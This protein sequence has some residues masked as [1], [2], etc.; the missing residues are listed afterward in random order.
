MLYF[1]AVHHVHVRIEPYHISN[2][3]SGCSFKTVTVQCF[4]HSY[5]KMHI[6]TFFK[7]TDAKYVMEHL[8]AT[9]ATHAWF[10]RATLPST[11]SSLSSS[12]EQASLAACLECQEIW[13][14]A[15]AKELETFKSWTLQQRQFITRIGHSMYLFCMYISVRKNRFVIISSCDIKVSIKQSISQN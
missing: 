4:W 11:Y 15:E 1:S 10:L 8:S 2:T 12:D 13:S 9:T 6:N 3:R 7:T 14:L 5:K